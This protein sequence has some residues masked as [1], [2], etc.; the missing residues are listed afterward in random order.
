MP[1]RPP[2]TL[3]PLIGLLLLGPSLA[4]AETPVRLQNVEVTATADDA[5]LP[6]ATSTDAETLEKRF[7]RSF[8]DLGRRAEPG[9]NFNRDNQSINIRGLDRDRVHTTVDGIRVPWLNDSIRGVSGG[10]DAID[11]QSLSA[12]DIVRGANSSQAGS[13]ALGGGVRLFTLAPEDLLGDGK[14]FGSLVKADHDSADGSRGLNAALA[15]RF[16]DTSWLIQAGLRSGHELETRGST[17]GYGN[18]RTE[19]L[20]ADL[21]QHNAL[22]KLRQRLAGGH[23]LGLTAELF[24]RE[25]EIDN[26]INQGTLNTSSPQYALGQ[27][28]STENNERKRVSIDHLYTSPDGGTLVDSAETIVYWQKIR[29]EDRQRAYRLG[30]V[31]GPFGR[32]NEIEKVQYG[33]TSTLSKKLANHALAVGAEWSRTTAEQYSA[34]YDNCP[35]P[36]RPPPATPFGLYYSCLNLHTNQ[37]EMP[38][39]PG[40]AWAVFLRDE[41]ALNDT[42]HLTPGLRYDSYRFDPRRTSGYVQN[43]NARILRDNEDS[44]L[45]GSLLLTWQATE[46]AMFYAQWA[47]GFKAPDANELYTTFINS[48]VGYAQMGN[49]DLKPEESNGYEI[50]ARLGDDKLGGSLSLFDNRYRNFID[51]ISAN[52]ED[53]GLSPGD[54][55]YGVGALGNR[56]KVRIYGAEAAVHWAFA[57]HWK[58]WGSVAWAVGKDRETK[59]H[60]NSIAPLTGIVGLGYERSHYGANLLLTAARAR[61]KVEDD[62]VDLRTPGYGVADLTGYWQPAALKGVRLHAGLFN[63][64]NKK[65]WNALNMPDGSAVGTRQPD[66]YYSEPGR[67]FRIALSWQH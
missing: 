1:P 24:E 51:T 53:Y 46:Q 22:I 27:N 25:K 60:L 36:L 14:T 4:L 40:T 5:V 29:R 65:Y 56:D 39:T 47:Q 33:L 61:N 59:Q 67:S 31:A 50:G 42:L 62:A 2:L 57:A 3:K 11:F 6:T 48:G 18:L 10:L 21:D 38:R 17:G 8:E 64:F 52:P 13:G 37:A 26:R 63:L 66:D 7:I 20:P 43:D 34:G 19:A 15:G 49:P 55:A 28:E 16:G 54:F 30:T 12:I 44:K 35:Q 45:S 23:R 41:I 9:V 58:L 32:T